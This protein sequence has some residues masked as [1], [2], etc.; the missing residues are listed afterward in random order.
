V[1]NPFNRQSILSERFSVLDRLTSARQDDMQMTLTTGTILRRITEADLSASSHKLATIILDGIAWK[2][3][4]NGLERG[5][6]AFTLGS[7]ADKMGVSRQHLAR[8]LAEL[9]ASALGL[10]RWKPHGKFAPWL[11][12]FGAVDNPATEPDLV[13][14]TDD[15]SLSRDSKNKMMFAGKIEIGAGS[16]VHRTPWAE[17]I[18][19]AKTAL[20]CWNVDTQ[21]IWDAFRAFNRARGNEQV[22]AGYLLGFMRKWRASSPKLAPR[23]TAWPEQTRKEDPKMQELHDQIR[24]APSSNRQFHASDLCRLIGQPAYDARILDVVRQFGC[25]RFAAILAV[26]G[27]AVTAGEIPK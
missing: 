6:A 19:A 24:A 7:L 16:N 3:G 4:Y 12:R 1:K 13:S 20:P 10:I 25:P 21:V 9:A 17:M 18:K 2:E 27:R 23:T 11:F 15:T 26:H 22:P 5:T 14:A 8:L